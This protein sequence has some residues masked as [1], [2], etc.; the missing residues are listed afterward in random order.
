MS[1]KEIITNP[2]S[3]DES[4]QSAPGGA[5]P[6]KKTEPAKSPDGKDKKKRAG[7]KPDARRML[8][9]LTLT[10]VFTAFAVV[11]KAFT[12]LAL[13]IPG[14]GIKVGFGGI[15]TF[16]P[17][18]LCGPVYG[19]IASGLS[20]LLG[21][22][23]APDGAY[24]PWLTLT[25]FAGGCIKGLLW[26][27]I[28][29]REAKRA[30]IILLAFFLIIGS[31]GAAFN[32][33]LVN[34]GV[35]SGITVAQAD[36]PNK[37][38]MN[39]AELSPLSSF[40][41]GL[42]QYNKD[43][44]TLRAESGEKVT[45]PTFADIDGWS[46]R[47]TKIAAGALE[48]CTG[49]VTIPSNY[50]S[51]DAAAFGE[52][53]TSGI[54]IVGVPGSA[55]ETF[56]ADRG[57]TFEAAASEIVSVKLMLS[58]ENMSVSGCT[59]STSDTYRKYLA[60]YINITVAGFEF[61][62]AVGLLFVGLNLLIRALERR[63]GKKKENAGEGEPSRDA[64]E[65]RVLSFIKIAAALTVAGLIVTTVNTF[66]LRAVMPAWT[67]RAILVLLIPRIAEELAVC[68][69]QAYVISLLYGVLARGKI[70][71]FIDKL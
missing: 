9:R 20:D 28:T 41:V 45:L 54:V 16:F 15:F 8:R 68:L 42:A 2:A 63:A 46:G 60:N 1:E 33:S 32:I 6:G 11:L 35:M 44:L 53:D 57:I 56:A 27:V 30:R 14:L 38:Q 67:G 70:K 23:V 7:R 10:A 52:T 17:A 65:S 13:Q 22:L 24:I 48:G 51:I 5:A 3:P 47:I 62:G 18:I 26:R 29:R 34:D 19:G 69:V 66:I 31:L 37:G 59:V 36:L 40:V 21:Y 50:T 25:A 61:T 39:N 43:T 4:G 49:R 64:G 12:N 55:A 58:A 71:A